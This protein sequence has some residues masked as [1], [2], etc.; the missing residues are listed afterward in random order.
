[1]VARLEAS[2]RRADFLDDTDTFVPEN[3]PRFAGRNVA[4]EDMQIGAADGRPGDADDGVGGRL[5]DPLGAVV[6]ALL[7]RAVYTRVFIIPPS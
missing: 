5:N 4:F 1:M 2:N 3:P 7:A 6:E